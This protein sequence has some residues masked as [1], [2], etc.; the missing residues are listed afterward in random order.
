[1][2]RSAWIAAL[3]ACL[4]VYAMYRMDWKR[5]KRRI[6]QH[7]RLYIIGGILGCVLLSGSSTFFYTLKKDSA[8]GRFLMW[9]ITAKAI[10]K[11]PITGT[12]LGGFPAAYAETQAEYMAS[13]KATEQEKWVAGCPEYAFNEYLQIGLEQGLIGLALFIAWLWLL[14]YKGIK[15]KRYACCGGLMSLAIFAFSSYPLQLPEFWVVL[16]FLGVMSVTPDKDEIRENQAESNGHRWGKQIFFMGIA[17]LGISLFWMQKDHYKAYQQ[18]NK[19]QMFYNNKA[20]EAALEVYEP[21]YPLLK[22]KP[23]FLFEAAQCLSKTGQ[24]EKANEYLKR[25]VL[26]SSDPMLYYVMAKNEQCLGEYRQAEKHLLHAIDI[27]PERIYP[28]YLLMNL[29]TEPS[30]FQPA[31][32]KMAIDSVLTK[33]PKVES[34]AI[35]EMKEKARS[36]LNNTSI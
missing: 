7:K 29:Y 32:L 5:I 22:H 8:D 17:I 1:M 25:A 6:R 13:G 31:K 30:Y 16:I 19:A 24:Y 27:L 33:K 20:Y 36:M 12:G 3:G 23:E 4:W 2:S 9:K 18:W 28:Y 35:K 26:L 10:R 21:L 34:S 15:N 14:F 11:Q